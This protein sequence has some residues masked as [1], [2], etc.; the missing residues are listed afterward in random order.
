MNVKFNHLFF[1]LFIIPSFL[2]WSGNRYSYGVTPSF[3]AVADTAA[4]LPF[5]KAIFLKKSD[6]W[7]SFKLPM[8]LAA[9]RSAI[10][11]LLLP[12]GT[13]LLNT[14]PP[15][16]LFLGARRNH[17]TNSLDVLNFS[18]PL[19]PISLI[20]LSTVAWL[21]TTFYISFSSFGM[22]GKFAIA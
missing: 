7:V 14:F 11:S 21:T 13:L 5:L 4:C 17:E 8:A 15:D 6:K 12:L 19:G 22:L 10:F 20:I 16:I 9:W 1:I 2:F 18:N 3:L